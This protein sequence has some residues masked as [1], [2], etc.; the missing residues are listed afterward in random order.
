MS[1]IL[2]I[3]NYFPPEKGAASNRIYNM[4]KSIK[5]M[6]NTVIEVICPLPNYPEGRIFKGYRRKIYKSEFIDNIKVIRI[7]T[8]ASNSKNALLRLIA[9]LSFGIGLILMIPKFHNSRYDKVIIQ[10]P[11]LI[12]AYIA[13]FIF[14][15][16]GIKIYLNV[17]DLWPLSAFELGVIGKGRLYSLL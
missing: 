11:P 6:E 2:V 5:K 4:V 15:F 12:S 8:F 10:S 9:M 3:S 1:R 7:W 17:S 16:L 13:T 14:R